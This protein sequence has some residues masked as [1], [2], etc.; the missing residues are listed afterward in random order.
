LSHTLRS[1]ANEEQWATDLSPKA[2]AMVHTKLQLDVDGTSAE[3]DLILQAHNLNFQYI[4]D[5]GGDK[6]PRKAP[7]EIVRDYLTKVFDYLLKAVEPF[8]EALRKT[9]PVDIVATV[10][11][12]GIPKH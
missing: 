1:Q 10:P 2:I 5:H 12:V 11:A 9:I 4:I 8:T 6:F 3:Q 7:E